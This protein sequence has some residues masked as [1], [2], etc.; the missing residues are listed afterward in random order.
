MAAKKYNAF[1]YGCFSCKNKLKI[2]FLR[3]DLGNRKEDLGDS[4]LR[5]ISW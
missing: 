1:S 5:N 4:I 2:N 3:K